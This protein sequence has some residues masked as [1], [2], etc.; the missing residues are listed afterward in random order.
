VHEHWNNAQEKLYGRNLGLDEGIELVALNVSKQPPRL[1][2]RRELSEV[3]V[4]WPSAHEGFQLESRDRLE[5]GSEW[6]PVMTALRGSTGSE[7]SVEC[8]GCGSYSISTCEVSLW[9]GID[10]GGLLRH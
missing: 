1:A 7:R 10:L 9:A 5:S 4:S 2:V 6:V 3:V 8:T